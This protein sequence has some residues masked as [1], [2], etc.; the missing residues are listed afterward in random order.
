MKRNSFLASVAAVAVLGLAGCG[1]DSDPLVADTDAGAD[2]GSDDALVVGSANFPESALLAE[3][4]AGALNGAGVEATT[5]PN[6]GSRETYLPGLLDGSI[7]VFPEYTGVLRDYFAVDSDTEV[8][9]TE[10]EEVFE[11]LKSVL[12]EELTVL[13]YSEAQDKDAV[14]VTRETAD[15]FS[16]SSIGDLAPVAGD[17]TLGGPP[18]WK[19]RSTGVPGLEKVY[20]VT[21]GDFIELDAGGPLTLKALLNGRVDAGNLFTT[22]PNIAAEDLVVLEDPESLFAAQN[23][24]PLLRT[25]AV[26]DEATTALEDV[27]AALDTETLGELVTRVV[28][29]KE[30]PEEVAADFLSEEGLS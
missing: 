2:S 1:G 6:I 15:E 12:P 30:D 13:Q 10:P 29:D 8:S 20:G 3:I 11:E 4:Y 17:M 22:D 9:G 18:E 16:L 27:S 7:D 14:V 26:T 28:I 24:V 21:F 23:V 19:T 25:D 5:R